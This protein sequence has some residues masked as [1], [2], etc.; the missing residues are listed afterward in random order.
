[1]DPETGRLARALEQAAE[2]A[3]KVP[4]PFQE[5]AFAVASRYLL[6][7]E[8]KGVDRSGGKPSEV[9]E[10]AQTEVPSVSDLLQG[11]SD[12]PGP[13][14]LLTALTQEGYFDQAKT[15]PELREH[16]RVKTGFSYGS[17][18]IGPALL[19]L[20]REGS[21]YRSKNEDGIYVYERPG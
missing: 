21:L 9:D 19:R 6:E 10:P 3:E 5:E 15:L 13:K 1:M 20:V 7:V 4:E 8:P 12:R 11:A 17:S 18:D 2:V 16:L 14:T